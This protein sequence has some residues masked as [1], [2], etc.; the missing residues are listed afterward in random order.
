MSKIVIEER[1]GS[2][3]LKSART[4]TIVDAAKQNGVVAFLLGG[5]SDTDIATLLC[6]AVNDLDADNLRL[7]SFFVHGMLRDDSYESV[8]YEISEHHR[9]SRMTHV[10]LQRVIN[11]KAIFGNREPDIQH[12]P[13]VPRD[14]AEKLCMLFNS[15]NQPSNE[16]TY[17]INVEKFDESQSLPVREVCG[18]FPGGYA[19]CEVLES[20]GDGSRMKCRHSLRVSTT[21]FEET[22]VREFYTKAGLGHGA[23]E[24]VVRDEYAFKA[25][26]PLF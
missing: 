13:M 9:D 23:V 11:Y 6:K 24:T 25:M 17:V 2:A 26:Q 19:Q 22:K 8:T 4:R 12:G 20:Y 7:S 21:P 5:L 18:N 10:T 14:L 1:T 16:K 3:Y 15:Y